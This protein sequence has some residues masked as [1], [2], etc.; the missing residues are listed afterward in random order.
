MIPALAP[1]PAR[2][3]QGALVAARMPDLKTVIHL[4]QQTVTGTLRFDDFIATG[5]AQDA[6]LAQIAATLDA[7]D[8][9]NI[10][11]TSGTTGFPKGATL[12]HP[13]S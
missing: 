3:A 2:C 10:Q 8:P 11:C 9:I 7:N 4:G 5:H 6:L 13:I 12:T 1:E